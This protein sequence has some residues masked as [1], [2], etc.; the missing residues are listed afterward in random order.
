[1][2]DVTEAMD[3]TVAVLLPLVLRSRIWRPLG[4]TDA[5]LKLR[6][7]RIL[8]IGCPGAWAGPYM[9]RGWGACCV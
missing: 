5:A 3:A 9:N 7:V 6:V 8:R 2:V 4:T 1:M